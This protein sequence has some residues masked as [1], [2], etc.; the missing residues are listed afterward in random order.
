MLLTDALQG[1]SLQEVPG[2]SPNQGF[3]E[4]L[5]NAVEVGHAE[6]PLGNSFST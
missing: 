1:L 5:A 4:G 3:V 2:Y 6:L